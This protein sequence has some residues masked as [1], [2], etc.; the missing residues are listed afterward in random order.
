MNNYIEKLKTYLAENPLGYED[1][2]VHSVLEFLYNCYMEE[3]C[4]DSDTIRANYKKID[5]ILSKLTLDENNAVFE[6]V[7]DLCTEHGKRAYLEG[8]RV[9]VRLEMEL[10]G[11]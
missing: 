7:C 9:G 10:S 2:N 6:S 3:T 8:I 5:D 1:E 4:S 11:K